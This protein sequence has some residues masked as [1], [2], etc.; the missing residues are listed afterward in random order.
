M[1]ATP[2]FDSYS[3]NE[4]DVVLWRALSPYPP[5]RYVEVTDTPAGGGDDTS[6]TRALYERGWSGLLVT[7]D[8]DLAARHRTLRPRDIAATARASS[9]DEPAADPKAPFVPERCVSSLIGDLGWDSEE[10]HVMVVDME[11]DGWAELEGAELGRWRPWIVVARASTVTDLEARGGLETMMSGKGYDRTMFD[12]RSCWFVATERSQRLAH[13]LSYPSRP[14]DARTSRAQRLLEAT[15]C[16]L[17]ESLA[18][19]SVDV[20]AWRSKALSAWASERCALAERDE[21]K[22]ALAAAVESNA[23]T[24]RAQMEEIRRLRAD[25]ADLRSST[26]WQV[27]APL[28]RVTSALKRNP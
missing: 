16:E 1:T 3:D 4:E 25:L 6:P 10:F 17:E 11:R 5:G 9:K 7:P 14:F 8:A 23:V 19:A 15:I 26:S 21:A 13:H 22:A 18:R 24:V 27:T 2:T 20:A 12:G 28:R